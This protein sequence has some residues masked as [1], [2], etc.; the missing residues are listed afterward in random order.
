M[1]VLDLAQKLRE[2]NNF[3]VLNAVLAGFYESVSDD[4]FKELQDIIFQD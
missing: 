2:L 3:A 4:I 1:Y